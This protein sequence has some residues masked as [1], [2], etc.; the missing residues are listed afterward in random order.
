MTREK[1]VLLLRR[2]RRDEVYKPSKKLLG[3]RMNYQFMRASY[4]RFLV[5]ELIRRINT[6][7]KDP[8]KIVQDLYY[9]MDDI[10]CESDRSKTWA[11]ASTMENCCA[12]I[13][14]YLREKEKDEDAKN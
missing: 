5:L 7:T 12:D 14:R 6:S 8:I 10:V 2:Y 3:W 4:E 1:A 9:E 11:F 13:L